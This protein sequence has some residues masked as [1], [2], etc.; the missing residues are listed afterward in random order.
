VVVADDDVVGADDELVEVAAFED[1][2]SQAAMVRPRTAATICIDRA[3]QDIATSE[4]ANRPSQG[5]RW[6]DF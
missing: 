5:S 1:E 3:L 6:A 4:S 2:P